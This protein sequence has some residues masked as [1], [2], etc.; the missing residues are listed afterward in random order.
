MRRILNK[1]KKVFRQI[2][3]YLFIHKFPYFLG[4]QVFHTY[5]ATP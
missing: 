1:I 3:L 2:Y 5:Q 4:F